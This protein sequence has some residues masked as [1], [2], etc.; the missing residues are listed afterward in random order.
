[1]GKMGT[2]GVRAR[3]EPITTI[4]G[5]PAYLTGVKGGDDVADEA[6]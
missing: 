6:E 4:A 5:S 3:R 2:L 1:M